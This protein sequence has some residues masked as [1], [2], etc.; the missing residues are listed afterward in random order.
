MQPNNKKEVYIRFQVRTQSPL[1]QATLE[2]HNPNNMQHIGKKIK[3]LRIGKNLKQ[4][5][6]AGVVGLS[7]TAYSN[8]ESGKTESITLQRLEQI[9]V[10]LKVDIAE[11]INPGHQN[12]DK[13]VD[14][15]INELQ[16]T[17][18]QLKKA[19][20]LIINLGGGGKSEILSNCV[21]GL[22]NHHTT[23][24]NC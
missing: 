4:R 10:A 18:K 14:A 16:Q 1:K 3:E 9:A 19:N 24:F 22:I 11:I 20:E 8:I 17:K 23:F 2:K 15:L 13:N 5:G 7:L 12:P 21:S 6:V